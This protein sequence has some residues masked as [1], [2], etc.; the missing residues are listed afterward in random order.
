MRKTLP[1]IE[2]PTVDK[3]A[4]DRTLSNIDVFN[5][6]PKTV[7]APWQSNSLTWSYSRWL[8]FLENAGMLENVAHPADRATQ[9]SVAAYIDYLS[10]CV[11]DST[12]STYIGFVIWAM[13][14]MFASADGE[15]APANNAAALA[16]FVPVVLWVLVAGFLIVRSRRRRLAEDRSNKTGEDE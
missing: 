11:K 9:R 1:P 8:G 12:R 14:L 10:G 4:W 15:R 5:P 6:G 16:A 2:W 3:E 13:V 7:R